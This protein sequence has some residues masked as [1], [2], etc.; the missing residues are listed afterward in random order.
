[1]TVNIEQLSAYFDSELNSEEHRAVAAHL[2]DCSECQAALR[3]WH[4]IS[5]ALMVTT[6]S[7]SDER[8][9]PAAILIGIAALLLVVGVAIAGP[10]NEIF[11]SGNVSGVGSR[12]VSLEEARV[13][14]LPLPRT[15]ELT[16]GWKVDQVQLVVTP[17]WRS[18]DVQYRRPGSRGMGITAWSQDIIVNPTADRREVVTVSGIPVELG[19]AGESVSARFTHGASTVIVRA[20]A[21]EVDLDGIRALVAAWIARAR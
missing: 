11:R 15:D 4:A 14:N 6:A 12:A 19:Y 9:A 17:T 13:A 5:R 1:M 18:V 2:P 3:H 7:L 16:G 8:R 21:D 20:F 10:F